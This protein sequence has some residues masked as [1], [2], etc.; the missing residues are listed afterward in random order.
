MTHHGLDMV[1]TKGDPEIAQECVKIARDLPD[2]FTD[3][4]IVNLIQDIKN[5]QLFVVNDFGKMLGFIVIA[6]IYPQSAEILWVAIRRNIN[7]K[8]M[9]RL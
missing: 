6:A 4:G 8:D 9:A 5:Y 7:I 3:S 1:I 2:Y